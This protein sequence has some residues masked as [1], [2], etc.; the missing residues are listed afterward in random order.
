MGVHGSKKIKI[1]GCWFGSREKIN[2]RE[3]ER[4]REREE[5]KRYN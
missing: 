3:R 5:A 4:E 1:A 2:G